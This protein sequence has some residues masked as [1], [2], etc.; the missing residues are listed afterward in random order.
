MTQQLSSFN[1]IPVTSPDRVVIRAVSYDSNQSVILLVRSIL[2]DQT[3]QLTQE[4]I[5]L[6][7]ANLAVQKIVPVPA[8]AL[9]LVSVVTDTT[10]V[11]DGAI[12]ASV[13]L[14]MRG[15][16]GIADILPLL[17]GWVSADHGLTWPNSLIERQL[18]DDIPTLLQGLTTPAVGSEINQSFSNLNS[19]YI[20]GG[21]FSFETVGGVLN[22][23][24][25]LNIICGGLTVAQFRSRTSQAPDNVGTYILWSGNNIPAD[26]ANVTYYL[27]L[28]TTRFGGTVQITTDTLNRGVNDNF[29]NIGLLSRRSIRAIA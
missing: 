19:L 20:D 9:T 28:P 6:L 7:T 15:Q 17:S 14:S 21:S 2:P 23:T 18:P 13:L 29:A 22:R 5:T 27:A 26:V 12:W 11:S 10:S 1:G 4:R 25:T 16:T 8:G 24:V 3:L